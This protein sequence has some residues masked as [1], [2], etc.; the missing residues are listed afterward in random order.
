LGVENAET[1]TI[2]SITVDLTEEP[3]KNEAPTSNPQVILK[4]IPDDNSCL[5]NAVGYVLENYSLTK[6]QELRSSK[7]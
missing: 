4:E 1:L 7:W 2:E 5:F 6:A 3:E